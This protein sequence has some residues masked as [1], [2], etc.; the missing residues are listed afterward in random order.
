MQDRLATGTYLSRCSAQYIP[1]KSKRL[2]VP[3]F[4]AKRK[5]GKSKSKTSFLDFLQRQRIVLLNY[6]WCYLGGIYR[7]W[8]GSLLE[9]H[10]LD[11]I[12]L[13]S[14]SVSHM[15]FPLSQVW[16]AFYSPL[17]TLWFICII[18]KLL[19]LEDFLLMVFGWFRFTA[20]SL[21]SHAVPNMH[22]WELHW[23]YYY[24]FLLSAR[25]KHFNVVEWI[26][27]TA[28]TWL[29]LSMVLTALLGRNLRSVKTY[30]QYQINPQTDPGKKNL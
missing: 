29:Y 6:L 17:L 23:D 16:N 13:V 3:C 7:L 15:S 19:E 12:N 9:A 10:S 5:E 20:A 11:C 24:F 18:P 25:C 2:S 4:D 27:T 30:Q 14:P 26:N 21:V 8:S 1:G 28:W 22:S